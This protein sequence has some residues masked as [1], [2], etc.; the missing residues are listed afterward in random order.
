MGASGPA[1]RKPGSAH[2][3][4]HIQNCELHDANGERLTTQRNSSQLERFKAAWTNPRRVS[5]QR[6]LGLRLDGLQNI[7]VR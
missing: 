2:S 6:D 4:S 5:G 7:V 1:P 3:F